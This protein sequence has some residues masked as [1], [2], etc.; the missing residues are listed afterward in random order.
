MRSV[1]ECS[2]TPLFTGTEREG[3][4]DNDWKTD[5]EE[6]HGN[7]DAEIKQKLELTRL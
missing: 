4:M 6:S 7:D 1:D 5:G 3:M 2:F